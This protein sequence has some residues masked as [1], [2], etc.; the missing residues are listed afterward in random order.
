MK[1]VHIVT[2]DGPAGVGKTTMARRVAD[3]LGIAY[4]DTGAMFRT[5]ALRLGDVTGM[6]E[7]EVRAKAEALRFELR[8][9]GAAT[10][11]LCDG[12]VVGDE[13]RTEE[14]GQMASR[15]AAVPVVREVLKDVQRRMGEHTSLVV[16]GRDMGTVVFPLAPFKFF[17]DAS[18][19][20]RALRRLG[21]LKAMGKSVPLGDLERQIRQ[22]DERDRNRAV[23]PLHPAPDALCIDTSMMTPDEVLDTMVRCVRRGAGRDGND[24]R[25]MRLGTLLD[26]VR[27][28]KPLVHFITNY[29]TVTDCA[30]ITLE[31]GGSPVMADAP[32]EVAQMV[33]HAQALV[34]NMGTLNTRTAES[35]H[36]AGCAANGAG[37]P[38]VLDPVGVGATALR[39]ETVRRLLAEVSFAVIKGN[40]SEMRYLV[41]G[42]GGASGVDVSADDMALRGDV[43]ACA[44]LALAVARKYDCVAVVSGP[45]DVVADRDRAFGVYNGH[46]Y[47]G[48]ITGSG[49]MAA[50]VLGVFAGTCPEM[51]AEATVAGMICMGLAGERAY[52][53]LPDRAGLGTFRT[54]LHDAMSTMTGADLSAFGRVRLLLPGRK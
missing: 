12:K 8:G 4:L 14:V 20:V 31:V 16:E 25:L 26:R 18:P 28:A 15:L 2:I 9:S 29:V 46:E 54:L 40:A 11:L 19:R 21:D 47:M 27:E 1:A 42:E 7:N 39:N 49:C 50:G 37:V 51:L 32:E 5:L 48:R 30:N 10:R 17:L 53:R 43:D 35:M 24:T 33:R 45:V 36:T 13:V 23:A 6:P 41:R 52:S 22:R 3:E 38:V 34:I 44:E